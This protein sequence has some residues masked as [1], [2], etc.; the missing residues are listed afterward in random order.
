MTEKAQAMADVSTDWLRS[1][2]A[3]KNLKVL[4]GRK[5]NAS[6]QSAG[7]QRTAAYWV[8]PVRLASKSSP[9]S[10]SPEI[11]SHSFAFPITRKTLTK[12]T[13]FNGGPSR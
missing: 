9:V 2:F 12:W 7:Q 11:T 8:V 13:K 10:G 5:L 1:S 6:Q 3:E 4:V